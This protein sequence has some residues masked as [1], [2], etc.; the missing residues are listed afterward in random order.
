[1][2]GIDLKKRITIEE[3]PDFKIRCSKIGNF[4]AGRIGLTEKQE[5]TFREY[6]ARLNGIGK[7]LTP[8]MKEAYLKLK[9]KKEN[10][11][12]LQGTKTILKDWAKGK[13]YGKR[14]LKIESKETNK[15]NLAENGAV[16]M[17]ERHL[18]LGFAKKNT[19]RKS[20]EW[21]HGECDIELADMIIDVKNSW[22]C[23]T[24]PLYD[25][26]D[27]VDSAYWW[28]GQGYMHLWGKKKYLLCYCLMD[29]PEELIW[30]LAKKQSYQ[31]HNKGRSIEEIATE[32]MLHY[33]YEHLPD[34]ERVKIFE[35]DYCPSAI[36]RVIERVKL[37]REYIKTLP[38]K[39]KVTVT[40]TF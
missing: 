14:K 17:L 31:L 1:M 19:V 39:N 5:I 9:E 13:Q 34:E 24:F 16:A 18:D 27:D 40:K 4:M 37:A 26:P 6:E 22:N 7:P 25:G 30:D 12:L 35:F 29:M 32:L 28:Q 11:E 20:D 21:M 38:Q 23:F 36:E 3:L 8:N 10:P 33:Q 15:G 2:S